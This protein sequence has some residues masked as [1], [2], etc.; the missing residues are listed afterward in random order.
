MI[1]KELKVLCF[2][3]LLQVLIIQDLRTFAAERVIANPGSVLRRQKENAATVLPQCR[4]CVVTPAA[5]YSRKWNETKGKVRH[6][7]MRQGSETRLRFWRFGV[8]IES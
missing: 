2:E 7:V 4:V 3:T 6:A 1:L 8:A 5:E